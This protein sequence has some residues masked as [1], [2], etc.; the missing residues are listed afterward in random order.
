ME[1]HH[2]KKRKKSSDNGSYT[3]FSHNFYFKKGA[4]EHVSASTQS[5]LRQNCR[6]FWPKRVWPGNSPDLNPIEGFWTL[7]RAAVTP[8]G[9]YGL[10][11]A[12]MRRRAI[13]WFNHITQEE[14]RK[15]TSGMVGR[16]VELEAADFWSIPH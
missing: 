5:Y 1:F 15:A 16:M 4:G 10:S 3:I 12:E 2:F 7:L 9:Q 13:V 8:V 11:N 14:C 6:N